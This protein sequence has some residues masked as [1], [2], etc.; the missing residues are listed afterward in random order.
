MKTA[1]QLFFCL[2]VI[3]TG[4]SGC[5]KE[6]TGEPEPISNIP[7]IKFVSIT[8]GTAVKYQDLIQIKIDYTDGDGDLG[9]NVSDVKNLFCTD[10][11]NNVTY[12]FR[13]RQLAP[14][15][16]NI[17][18]TGRLSFEL[19]PQGFIDDNNTT[20]TATYSIYVKDRAGNQSNTVQTTPLTIN[21]Q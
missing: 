11:R 20:E 2:V 16:A 1:S 13:I 19:D 9:E 3:L 21:S 18:I 10:S 7:S 5:G 17:A 14:D 15:S 8:P 4:L 6:N 12:Q